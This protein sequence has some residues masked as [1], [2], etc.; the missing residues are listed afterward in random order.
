QQGGRLWRR[1]I[2]WRR[3]DDRRRRNGRRGS[4]LVPAV[5]PLGEFHSARFLIVALMRIRART[6]ANL[7]PASGSLASRRMASA[8]L[9]S[10]I[11]ASALHA[12]TRTSVSHCRSCAMLP[13][14]V[15]DSASP[16]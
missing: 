7:T 8:P 13:A 15:S 9:G 1:H 12:A 5:E 2:L 4:L 11:I 16:P 3:N 6:A 14:S 10:P